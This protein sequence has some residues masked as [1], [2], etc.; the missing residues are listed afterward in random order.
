MS[1]RTD[2]IMKRSFKD[3]PDKRVLKLHRFFQYV[4]PLAITALLAYLI[5]TLFYNPSSELVL[6]SRILLASFFTVEFAV[7]FILYESKKKFVKNYWWRAALF[8][9]VI[10]FLRI[11]GQLAQLTYFLPIVKIMEK[12]SDTVEYYKSKWKE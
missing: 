9:P 6:V 11:L 1:G 4:S 12:V 8:I 2:F 10:G 5:A 7:E 3:D